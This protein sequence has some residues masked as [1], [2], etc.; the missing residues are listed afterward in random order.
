MYDS[1]E[2]RNL[3]AGKFVESGGGEKADKI[4][5]LLKLMALVGT[6]SGGK[7]ISQIALAYLMAK[8]EPSAKLCWG[9]LHCDMLCSA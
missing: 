1:V 9:V 8:G 5:P 6:F 4:R 3:L 2:L 7:S